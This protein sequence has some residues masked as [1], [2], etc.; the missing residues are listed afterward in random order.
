MPMSVY[1]FEVATPDVDAELRRILA[2]TPMPGQVAVSFRREPSY[3]AA[4]V[5]DGKFHQVITARDCVA[6]RLIGFGARS[7]RDMYV[8]G[9]VEPIGY[10]NGL[11]C[12]AEHRNRGLVARGYA[13]FR[14]LHA[15]GRTRIYLTTI[16]QGNESALAI[17]TSGRA[18]LPAY[19]FAGNYL[20]AALPLGQCRA[21][22]N[23]GI[24]PAMEE[25]LPAILSFL[26]SVGPGRQFF[27][28]Y[29]VEDF[30]H[31]H[32]T[33]RDLQPADLLLAYR[34]ERLVGM[35]AGWDQQAFRQT[36]V[37]GYETPLR[38][39]RPFYN[40]WARCRSLP[41]LPAPG[42][43]FSYLTAALPLV[44]D[45][46]P[47]IFGALLENLLARR[48]KDREYLLLGLHEADPLLAVVR[49]YRARWYTTR[50]HLVCWEDGEELRAGLEARPPYLELGSL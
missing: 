33:F 48:R 42:Q 36:V 22:T 32:G 23:G 31:P 18:G 41:E 47:A 20:T 40:C 50:L 39:L 15:D 5:V 34:G 29:E 4:A 30:F 44:A 46:D 16:A 10:L 49:S 26:N 11:R 1:R 38:W 6:D 9:R 2:E 37:Q 19:H 27:P 13:F 14:K 21:L 12:L 43:A 7:I 28:R 35:L 17:L 3:F 24:R 8:N 25:D 45:D